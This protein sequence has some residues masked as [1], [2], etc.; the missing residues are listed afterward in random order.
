MVPPSS[1][2]MASKV[3]DIP[4]RDAGIGL[5][6][7]DAARPATATLKVGDKNVDLNLRKGQLG[8]DVIDIRK[9]YR[10]TGMFTYDP[11]FTSTASCELEDHLHRWR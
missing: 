11:G 5:G 6:G 7:G 1:P 8:P 10:E 4:S 9:L 3:Q 2:K